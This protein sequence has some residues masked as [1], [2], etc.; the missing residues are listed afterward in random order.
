MPVGRAAGCQWAEAKNTRGRRPWMPGARSED[1]R[2][3]G[4]GCQGAEARGAEAQ[5]VGE[6]RPWRDIGKRETGAG[7]L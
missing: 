6:Q 2:G 3:G 1:A 7:R 5:A 4:P